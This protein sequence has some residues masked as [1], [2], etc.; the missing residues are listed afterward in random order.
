MGKR[1][2]SGKEMPMRDKILRYLGL[3]K[4]TEAEKFY[5][6]RANTKASIYMSIVVAS[7]EI[8]MI[9]RTFGIIADSSRSAE[10]VVTHISAYII[11]L[12]SAAIMLLYSYRFLSGKTNNRQ[13]GF[14]L[15]VLFSIVCIIFG[16]YI[17]LHDYAKG[18]HILT[19][20]TM[21]IFVG[22]L[23]A[24][25]PIVSFFLLSGSFGL[26]YIIIDNSLLKLP[27][28][29]QEPATAAT[30]INLFVMWISV[31][32]VSLSMYYQRLE[33]AGKD[34]SNSIANDHLR[35]MAET[36]SLTG[37]YSRPHF[38]ALAKQ[39]LALAFDKDMIFLFLDITN[40]KSYNEKYGYE[41]GNNLL[42]SVGG[43]IRKIFPDDI[44]SRFSDDHFALMTHK[45]GL[46]EK[47]DLLSEHVKSCDPESGI[48]LKC[49]AFIP[50]DSS[51]DP[52]AACDNARY[53]C[54]TL[55]KSGLRY[56][57]Y[58][59][60]MEADLRRRRYIL[61]NIEKAV[62][63]GYIKAYYQPVVWAEDKRICSV[64]AL[65]RWDDPEYGFLSP[66]AFIP[67][68]EEYRKIHILD[69]AIVDI[70]CSDMRR[71]LDSGMPAIPISI[72]FSRLDFELAD[73]PEL[74][75]TTVEKYRLDRQ[76]IHVE[77]TESALNSSDSLLRESTMRLKEAGYPLWLDDFGS[78]YSSLNVL[79]D[80]NFDV[81]KLDMQF[82][83]NF[84]TNKKAGVIIDCMLKMAEQI[85]IHTLSEGV[86]TAEEADFLKSVGCERLQGYLIGKPMPFDELYEKIKNG[87][88]T[89]S[90]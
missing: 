27:F 57:E 50:A 67:V 15:R 86:E 61:N 90:E 17:S 59:D 51:C 68:L 73:I 79:K 75:E 48:D 71:Y 89:V 37:L 11:L 26:F 40:F 60:K 55:K 53:V 28:L 3:D 30:G 52:A 35:Q 43:T 64:E 82:L 44:Y 39:R 31:L 88:Y 83:T 24:W 87:T 85:G 38:M 1:I 21:M 29:P 42:K 72:N 45:T 56:G 74:L 6:D 76:K 47:L 41:W 58:D 16:M 18:E 33:E 80:F 14:W 65:A 22:C 13:L 78:G 5:F 32:M 46:D 69:A 49:G 10:W 66:A 36:D 2:N 34:E 25:K 81:L 84:S 77:I 19:F 23:Y 54:S 62:K 7:L 12:T 63:S 4:R 8:W 70:A 20:V 9:L